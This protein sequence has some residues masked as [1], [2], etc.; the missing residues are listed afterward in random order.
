MRLFC[1]SAIK[2]MELYSTKNLVILTAVS[3]QLS[4]AVVLI[5]SVPGNTSRWVVSRCSFRFSSLRNCS[6]LCCRSARVSYDTTTKAANDT[7]MSKSQVVGFSC[8]SARSKLDQQ[9]L[10]SCTMD[11]RQRGAASP[12]PAGIRLQ[13]CYLFHHLLNHH[14]FINVQ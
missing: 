2:A 11:L 14:G 13:P 4:R 10:Y 1:V 9:R 3:I 6:L 5:K 8:S 7:D 12:H